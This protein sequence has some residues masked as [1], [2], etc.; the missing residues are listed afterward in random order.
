M[1]RLGI[2]ERYY[3]VPYGFEKGIARMKGQGYSAMD[4]PEFGNTETE[5]FRKNHQQF[6]E[7]LEY[8][9]MVCNREGIEIFQTHGPWR[10]PPR[11]FTEEDRAERFEK[12]SRAIEGTAILRCKNIVIHPLMPFTINDEG[13]EKETYEI[14]L[15]FF[16]RLCKVAEEYGVI[17]NFE[18]MPMR[19][20][21]LASTSEMLKLVKE[22]DSDYFKVCLDTGH[23]SAIGNL[24]AEDV[25]LLGKEYLSSLHIHD[26]DGRH[27]YHWYPFAGVIDWKDFCNA[28][29]EIQYDGV[30]NLEVGRQKNLPEELRELEEVFLYR[31]IECLAK[32]V[33]GE[34]IKC[35]NY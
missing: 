28:L 32:M 14:N 5:L 35:D 33:V 24:P 7:Y 11:D 15:D 31:R 10:Y 6:T 13:H 26:N 3:T 29:C 22:I 34:N 21:A 23:S 9:A 1:L 16:G 19:H 25:R 2:G 17:I 30:L 8:Q 4:Y 20:F 18:N 27:D 12:M